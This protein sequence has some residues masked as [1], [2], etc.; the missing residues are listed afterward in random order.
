VL[1][2]P[3][4]NNMKKPRDSVQFERM[5]CRCAEMRM[6]K[7]NPPMQYFSLL[8]RSGKKQYGGDIHSEDWTIIIQ[9]KCYDQNKKD[10]YKRVFNKIKEDYSKACG[11]YDKMQT[12]VIATTLDGPWPNKKDKD[13]EDIAE[14]IPKTKSA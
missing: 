13:D 11:Y 2:L 4:E 6:W 5:V 1:D 3:K 7:A 10:S 8:G 12:F 9:C 14:A